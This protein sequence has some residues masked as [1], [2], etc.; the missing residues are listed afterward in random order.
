MGCGLY[1]EEVPP[2]ED[3]AA[4]IVRVDDDYRGGAIVGEGPDAGKVHLPGAAREQVVEAGLDT[5]HATG[6]LVGREARPRQQHVAAAGGQRRQAHLQR[7]RPP[8][9]KEDVVLRR[10]RYRSAAGRRRTPRQVLRHGP[11]G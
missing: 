6:G 1:L 3:G 8:A 7:L 10:R 4:G 2:G 9:G 5:V 11:A